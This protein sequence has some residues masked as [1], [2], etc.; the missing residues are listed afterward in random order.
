MS[1]VRSY[2]NFCESAGISP[3]PV[4]E[5]SLCF[6]A[7]YSSNRGIACKTTKVYITGVLHQNSM[8]GANAPYPLCPFYT[9]LSEASDVVKATPSP[10]KK[11]KPITTSHSGKY[12]NFC[13]SVATRRTTNTCSWLPPKIRSALQHRV[14]YHIITN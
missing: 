13:S 10:A 7:V 3:F 1:G 6:F 8:L 12:P 9:A 11:R 2:L 14:F 5:A 4:S